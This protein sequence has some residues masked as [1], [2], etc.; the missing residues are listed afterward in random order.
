VPH[1][2]E[3]QC[4]YIVIGNAVQRGFSIV[5][6]CT[7]SLWRMFTIVVIDNITI[8]TELLLLFIVSGRA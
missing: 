8:A 3:T 5:Y 6:G 1:F 4:S 2:F 7:V